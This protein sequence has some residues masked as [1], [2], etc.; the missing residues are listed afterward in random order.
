MSVTFTELRAS[1]CGC[2]NSGSCTHGG[3]WNTGPR[4][5]GT[6]VP[7]SLAIAPTICPLGATQ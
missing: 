1:K 5:S 7:S 4:L 6:S 2:R 3:T